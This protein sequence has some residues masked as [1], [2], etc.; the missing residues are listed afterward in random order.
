MTE[1]DMPLLRWHVEPA[2][3]ATIV[4]LTGEIDLGTRPAFAAAIDKARS[5]PTD[6]IV[7]D[8]TNVS[9]IG[10]VGIQVLI[11]AHRQVDRQVRIAHGGGIARRAF[12]ISGVHEV[13]SVYETLEQARTA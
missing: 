1:A 11:E 4:H 2:R 13:L 9:F 6:L 5:A 12:E 3:D 10:S 8:L 7:I